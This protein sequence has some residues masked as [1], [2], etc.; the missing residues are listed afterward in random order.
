[1]K[2]LSDSVPVPSGGNAPCSTRP[3]IR[4]SLS[5]AKSSPP[6]GI[7]IRSAV[8]SKLNLAEEEITNVNQHCREKDQQPFP[9]PEE[10]RWSLS[11]L[12]RGA[13]Q[14]STK[15]TEVVETQSDG[16]DFHSQSGMLDAALLDAGT[17][18]D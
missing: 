9:Q 13:A 7:G 16:T 18:V 2:L 4:V 6:G 8:E 1:M 15:D 11:S 12:Y 14:L 3:G 17:Q 10:V 5:R